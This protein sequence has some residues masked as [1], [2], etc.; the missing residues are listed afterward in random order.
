M[1]TPTAAQLADRR[2]RAVEALAGLGA[3]GLLVTTLV[4]VRYLTG[5]TGSNGA[6]VLAADGAGTFLT[7]VSK[8]WA[9]E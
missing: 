1:S 4:N 8:A 3:D 7:D 6:L 9:N 2:G 5:F